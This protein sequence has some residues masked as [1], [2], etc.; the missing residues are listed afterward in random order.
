MPVI[1]SNSN[2]NYVLNI[3]V[4]LAFKKNSH[5]HWPIRFNVKF[6]S[7]DIVSFRSF[8]IVCMCACWLKMIEM[9]SSY[10]AWKHLLKVCTG[11]CVWVILENR[12]VP[13]FM[14]TCAAA[15]QTSEAV[16][17]SLPAIYFKIQILNRERY[18]ASLLF[19]FNLSLSLFLSVAQ[20]NTGYEKGFRMST[21]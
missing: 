17:E 7:F 14:M 18:N 15:G 3:I 20:F 21:T 4:M 1:Y 19:S 5:Q 6:S 9:N 8:T 16:P 12:A 10:L 13:T 2:F 11:V